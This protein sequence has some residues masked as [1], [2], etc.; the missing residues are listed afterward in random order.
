MDKND[1][2][3]RF[4]LLELNELTSSSTAAEG[5]LPAPD[6][7]DS[8]AIEWDTS[9]DTTPNASRDLDA[10][11]VGPLDG[12][13]GS[14]PGSDFRRTKDHTTLSSLASAMPELQ[15]TV[16]KEPLYISGGEPMPSA[17]GTVR[18]YPDGTREP[19]GT[20]GERYTVLQDSEA[21]RIIEPLVDSGTISALDGGRYK[22][23]IWVYGQS[24]LEAEITR[25][26]SV[27]ARVIVANS[28]DGS[29]PWSM[30]FPIK[31]PVC[32]NTLAMALSSSLSKLLKVRHTANAQEIVDQVKR[33]VA[34]FG[35]EFVAAADK[36]RE[37]ARIKVTEAQVK[38][39]TGFVFSRWADQDD[40]DS[41]NARESRVM[42]KVL[43][44]Y[45][46]GRGAELRR[47]T[48]WGAYSAV[49]EYL[50]HD[51]SRNPGSEAAF[52]DL[53]WGGGSVLNRRAWE[54]AQSFLSA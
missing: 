53:Q 52:A 37:L 6:L 11:W 32:E 20:V 54:G 18:T 1:T 3:T 9:P 19:L 24:G 25:G 14:R 15:A 27:K 40:E 48:A 31:Q 4:S 44:N 46:T 47:G 33:A 7:D 50:T 5:L 38:E 29:L 22:G 30:G 8:V 16:T 28:H 17:Y 13:V 2:D 36:M 43:E 12:A 51:R 35:M 10:S 49:T 26:D 21:L 45:E 41:E 39:Y 23:K 34:Q 42:V